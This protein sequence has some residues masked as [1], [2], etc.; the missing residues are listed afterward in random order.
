MNG[1]LVWSWHLTCYQWKRTNEASKHLR[2]RNSKNKGKREKHEKDNAKLKTLKA[3]NERRK[4]SL[5][6]WEWRKRLF[7]FELV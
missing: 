4:N 6:E 7:L 5:R 3:F 1:S 2:H